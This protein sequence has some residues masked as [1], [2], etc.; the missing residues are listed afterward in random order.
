MSA[1][2]ASEC[3]SPERKSVRNP[4]ESLIFSAVKYWRKHLLPPTPKALNVAPALWTTEYR[5]RIEFAIHRE[6]QGAALKATIDYYWQHACVPT[7]AALS[8]LLGFVVSPEVLETCGYK[9]P[10]EVIGRYRSMGG[11]VAERRAQDFSKR[12]TGAVGSGIPGD[13][14]WEEAWCDRLGIPFAP[15]TDR[16]HRRLRA[17]VRGLK[18]LEHPRLSSKDV[19]E[20]VW[21]FQAVSILSSREE[22]RRHLAMIKGR[23]KKRKRPRAPRIPQP[24]QCVFTGW[25]RG[26]IRVHVWGVS[27]E[28]EDPL[29]PDPNQQELFPEAAALKRPRA[30]AGA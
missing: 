6:Q 21:L 27:D 15:G 28:G 10:V 14:Q 26:L 24:D 4:Q 30:A 18:V 17:L 19:E 13:Y 20:G 22:Q 12:I 1:N 11:D 5:K 8:A 9:R 16:A 2:T 29:P 23:E 25:E 3:S 7:P